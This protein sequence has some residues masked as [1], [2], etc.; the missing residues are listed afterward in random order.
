MVQR[1]LFIGGTAFMGARAVARLVDDGHDVTVFHRGQTDRVPDGVQ[2]LHGDRADLLAHREA[3]RAL[4]PDVVVHMLA[5][6]A[7]DAWDAR[8][9]FEGMVDRLVLASSIDV[10]AAYGRLVT[11]SEEPRFPTPLDESSALRAALYPRRAFATD[12]EDPERRAR[13]QAYDKIVV[14]AVLQASRAFAV[15]TLRL[16]MVHG[17]H[18]PQRRFGGYVTRM[19]EGRPAILLEQTHAAWRGTRAYVDDMGLALAHAATKPFEEHR[20]F[21]VGETPS[22]TER[23]WIAAL[24]AEIGY[25]GELLELPDDVLPAPLKAGADFRQPLDIDDAA[26]REALELPDPT[27]LAEQIAATVADERAR[28]PLPYDREAEDAVIARHSR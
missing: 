4:R 10:V 17:P 5:A 27:P 26:A 15:T 21:L 18:D 24:A 23:E 6:T 14:E 3:F 16:P 13:L 22:R 19:D 1:I 2:H 11:P 7:Q 9:T 20:T 12:V 8:Q 25:T 28:G